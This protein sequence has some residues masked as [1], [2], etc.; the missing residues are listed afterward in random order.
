MGE[1]AAGRLDTH[2]NDRIR[3]GEGSSAPQPNLATI[4][5]DQIAA[6]GTERE[7]SMVAEIRARPADA[8]PICTLKRAQ[9]SCRALKVQ[10]THICAFKYIGGIILREIAGPD[11]CYAPVGGFV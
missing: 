4:E 5:C 2:R 6:V 9:H 1:L 11:P 7:H 8:G 3:Y 10:H